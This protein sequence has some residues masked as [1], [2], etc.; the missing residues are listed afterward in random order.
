MSINWFDAKELAG[1][2][3]DAV[4]APVVMLLL[5]VQAGLVEG[6]QR[7]ASGVDGEAR[8]R[9]RVAVWQQLLLAPIVRCHA[10]QGYVY[11]SDVVV[12]WG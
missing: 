8:D 9:L 2:L 4:V 6:V 5:S 7:V 3:P 10:E 11:V 12:A 1:R